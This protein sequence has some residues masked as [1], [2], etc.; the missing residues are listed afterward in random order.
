MPMSLQVL[1]SP[2]LLAWELQNILS[3]GRVS[4]RNRSEHVMAVGGD[5]VGDL[6]K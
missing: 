1:W 5:I 4:Q 6:K 2:G 3:D